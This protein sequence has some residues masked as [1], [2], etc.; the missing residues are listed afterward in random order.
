MKV[1]GNAQRNY[2]LDILAEK[3]ALH[4]CFIYYLDDDNI[5]HPNLYNLFKFVKKNNIYT[6]DQKRLS[7]IDGSYGET[8][9]GN[10][11][12]WKKVDTS[13]ILLYYPLIKN[14]RWNI[15]IYQSDYCYIKNAVLTTIKF[16]NIFLLKYLIGII[17]K[18]QF[19]I[20]V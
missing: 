6:F 3:K 20:I 15:N 7:N 19:N 2:A 17:C 1:I 14:I 5:I 11:I 4:N 18:Y 13:Q 12:S 8:L 10:D 9:K 16:I